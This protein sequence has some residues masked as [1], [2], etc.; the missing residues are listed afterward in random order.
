MIWI[1]EDVDVIRPRSL[2]IDWMLSFVLKIFQNDFIKMQEYH[3][4]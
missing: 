3:E 4:R 2:N 1:G